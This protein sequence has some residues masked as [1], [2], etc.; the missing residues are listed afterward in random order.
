MLEGLLLLVQLVVIWCR[1]FHEVICHM[2]FLLLDALQI[3]LYIVAWL[4]WQ[5][6][7]V[8]LRGCMQ[9]AFQVAVATV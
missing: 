6:K 3:A 1:P 8:V 4:D 5:C 7:Q 2:C 9:M